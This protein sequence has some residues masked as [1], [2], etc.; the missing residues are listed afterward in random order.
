MLGVLV[1][2]V[3]ENEEFRFRA[4]IRG[5]RVSQCLH[6]GFRLLRN[7]ARITGVGAIVNR[8][9]DIT[10]KDEGR[11]FEERIN[12]GRRR[13]RNDQHVGLIDRLPAS[14]AGAVETEPLDKGVL[15]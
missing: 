14:N 4:E 15:L 13:V 6:K 7:V 2:D 12:E 10:G 1:T 8:I 3:I 9:F 5:I 11:R